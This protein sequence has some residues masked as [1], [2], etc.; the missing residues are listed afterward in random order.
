MVAAGGSMRGS[1]PNFRRGDAVAA[2]WLP[3]GVVT[4]SSGSGYRN[5]RR[6]LPANRITPH[7]S[8]LNPRCKI[9]F[10]NFSTSGAA[11]IPPRRRGATPPHLRRGAPVFAPLL[12][13]GGAT[14]SRRGWL[15]AG[16]LPAAPGVRGS[17]KN[18]HLT[19][20]YQ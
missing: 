20:R 8:P 16:W 9:D 14:R 6:W 11:G 12:I 4:G 13:S 18:Y 3:T 10:F 15:P 17:G 1:P 19:M 5:P 7:T 2:G